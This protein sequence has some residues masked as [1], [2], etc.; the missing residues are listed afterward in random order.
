MGRRRFRDAAVKRTILFICIGNASRSQMAE[1][2]VN[3]RMGDMYQ[4]SSA[5]LYP[6]RVSR[7][8]IAVMKDVGIDI[9]EHRSKSVEEFYGKEFDCI[10]TLCDEAEDECPHFLKGKDYI[11]KGFKDPC[12]AKGTDEELMAVYRQ[13]RDDL[14]KWIDNNFG[15][16]A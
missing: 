11:H 8:A 9:S 15:P 1:G 4:A 3:A 10:V 5:G 16:G 13:T 12:K 7:K 14:F 6:E 2:Y